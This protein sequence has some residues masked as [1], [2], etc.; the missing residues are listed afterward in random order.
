MNKRLSKILVDEQLRLKEIVINRG[1]GRGS[2][3][4]A[5]QMLSLPKGGYFLWL[6]GFVQYPKDL[7]KHLGRED[8]KI[9]TPYF[10]ETN[11]YL[12]LQ[13]PALRVDH[14]FSPTPRQYE[15]LERIQ[16]RVK[17]TRFKVK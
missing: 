15:A 10:L 14:A 6:N 7:A 17:E 5:R 12:Q 9:V 11:D 2:G 3:R 1:G 8:I 16:L 4:T 13:I